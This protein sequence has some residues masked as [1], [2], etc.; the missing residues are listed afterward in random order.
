MMT[1]GVGFLEGFLLYIKLFALAEVNVL[2]RERFAIR[3]VV[4]LSQFKA[5]RVIN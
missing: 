2:K 3:S 4:Y 1:L 5:E